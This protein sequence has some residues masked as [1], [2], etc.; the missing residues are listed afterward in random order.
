MANG[1]LSFAGRLA[2]SA[3]AARRAVASPR[4][5]DMVALLGDASSGPALR[6]LA[7][8]VRRRN[9]HLLPGSDGEVGRHPVPDRFPA[10]TLDELLALP[11]HSLGREYARFMSERAFDPTERDAVDARVVPEPDLAWVLQRYRDVHDLWHVL[12]AMPTT[13]LGEIGQKWFE[14][15]HTG[16]PVAVL[17]SLMGP[18]RL[19]AAERRVLVR[20]LIPWALVA[21][22]SCVNLLAIRYEDNMHR[23]IDDVR[24]E[25]KITPPHSY[26][27]EPRILYKKQSVPGA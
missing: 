20:D 4:R 13:L 21:G 23:D 27:Q 16:L 22:S 5:A 8:R 14:A 2:V 10:A 6:V 24:R 9:P 3:V 25:W 19:N 26:L 18:V 1:G 12:N 11:E 7:E 15:T 17:S